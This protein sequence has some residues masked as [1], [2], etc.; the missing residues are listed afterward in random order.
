MNANDE[1]RMKCLELAVK[2][3]VQESS[4]I[5]IVIKA[6]EFHTF[7]TGTTSPAESAARTT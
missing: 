4:A 1:V 6:R 5:D 3:A 7:V 2:L